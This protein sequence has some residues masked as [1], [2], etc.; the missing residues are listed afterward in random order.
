MLLLFDLIILVVDWIYE[1][2][3]FMVSLFECV[4][5]WLGK[6]GGWSLN[7]NLYFDF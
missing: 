5:V 6:L 4:N 7:F 3:I 1:V 2:M